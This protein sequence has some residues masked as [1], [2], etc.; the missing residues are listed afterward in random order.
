MTSNKSTIPKPIL[1]ACLKIT[2][3]R[4]KTVVD[5]IL[6]HGSITTEELKEI[7]SYDHPPR[8]IRDVR[9]HGIPIETFKVQSTATGRRIA[10]YRIDTENTVKKGRIGGR[11]AFSKSFK[12]RLVKKYESKNATTYEELDPRYL[13]IDHRIPYEISGNDAD[14][15]DL[16]AFMLLDASAQRAKSWSCEH[17]Q[18]FLNHQDPEI[19]KSCFWA[20]PEDYSHV[21]M[22]EE[23][24]VWLVWN[25]CEVEDYTKLKKTAA[26]QGISIQE[27]IKSNIKMLT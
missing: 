25:G 22:K 12:D 19:C 27:L 6:K 3:K 16:D 24:R 17:C 13:Q 10:A 4:P 9:E 5:H 20:Y 18:N 23:R 15:E 14:L 1:D 8:A 11:T 2:A 26:D 7:Y 21:A